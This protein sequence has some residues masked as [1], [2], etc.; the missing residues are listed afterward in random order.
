MAAVRS[1][2]ELPSAGNDFDY[3]SSYTSFQQYTSMQETRLLQLYELLL[4]LFYIVSIDITELPNTVGR[5]QIQ[6][7]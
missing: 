1:S 7:Y 6:R 2:N 3:Y 5:W 4:F